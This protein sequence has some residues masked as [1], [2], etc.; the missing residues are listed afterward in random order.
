L[1]A[2]NYQWTTS[3]GTFSSSIIANPWFTPQESGLTILSLTASNSF[4]SNQFTQEV[5]I[6]VEPN[7]TALFSPSTF[8]TTLPNALVQFTNASTNAISYQW[9]FGDG[10]QSTIQSPGHQYTT[11]GV[12]PV[13]L[14][15]EA[16]MCK[17]DTLIQEITV[18]F[19]EL[20]EIDS[21]TLVYPIPF[22]DELLIQ[23]LLLE[24][25]RIFDMAGRKVFESDCIQNGHITG[26]GILQTGAYFLVAGKDNVHWSVRIYKD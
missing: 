12:F 10:S 14:I 20:K 17:S 25:C 15:A 13:T 16:T 23:G 4:G 24:W 7:A 19:L 6:A 22:E 1:N 11:S 3:N 26:L 2:T 8:L 21:T 9:D 18:G 5:T